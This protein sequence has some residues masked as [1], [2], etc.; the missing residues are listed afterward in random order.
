MLTG[1]FYLILRGCLGE[2]FLVRECI[3]S[4]KIVWEYMRNIIIFMSMLTK[5]TYIGIIFL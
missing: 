3:C 1:L 2:F 5:F 4:C